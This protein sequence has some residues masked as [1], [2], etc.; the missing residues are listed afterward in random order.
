M[1][2]Q[3]HPNGEKQ[4]GRTNQARAGRTTGGRT[5]GGRTMFGPRHG[6]ARHP[7][8]RLDTPDDPAAAH[9]W[10]PRSGTC[11]L[12]ATPIE[13]DAAADPNGWSHRM[14]T[15]YPYGS[16]GP[17]GPTKT[18]DSLNSSGSLIQLVLP[19]SRSCCGPA[20]H[21]SWGPPLRRARF[22]SPASGRHH[23]HGPWGPLAVRSYLFHR[24]FLR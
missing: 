4:V 16:S 8:D 10:C 14:M 19:A 2:G 9:R 12:R 3:A 5:T 11:A 22:L 24:W 13:P 21:P 1:P 20:G 18:C 15:S 17:V 7:P 23:S 6:A